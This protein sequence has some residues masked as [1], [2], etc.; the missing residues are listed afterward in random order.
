MLDGLV[1]DLAPRLLIAI[2]GV[3]VAFLVLIAVL[4]FLRRRNSPLFVKGGRAREHRLLVL[5][6]AA[7]DAKRRLVLIKRD[8]I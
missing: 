2:G 1:P 3:A 4:L 5:D 6:A 7:V 8:D